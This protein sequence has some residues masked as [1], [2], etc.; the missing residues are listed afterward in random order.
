MD[1]TKI[2]ILL[3]LDGMIFNRLLRDAAGPFLLRQWKKMDKENILTIEDY[4]LPEI[5]RIQDKVFSCVNREKSVNHSRAFRDIFY[6]T[7]NKD[8]VLNC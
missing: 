8:K 2:H 1:L 3:N 7:E 5:I 4:M 6:A